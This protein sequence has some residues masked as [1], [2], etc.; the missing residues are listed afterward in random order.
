MGQNSKMTED[1]HVEIARLQ[2][3]IGNYIG[4]G[5]NSLI[6]EF[7][8]GKKKVKLHLIT[9]NPRHSQSFLFHSEEGLDKI[10]ALKKMLDYVKNYKDRESS[11][12]IQWTLKG[13]NE[14]HTSYFSARNVLDALDK[15]F[16]GREPNSVTV[17]SVILNPMT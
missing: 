9:V 1:K 17:F 11:F 3:E 14:L 8:E 4:L 10:D 15:L 16:Y 13:E 7:K 5:Q 12:T 2:N 6:Y